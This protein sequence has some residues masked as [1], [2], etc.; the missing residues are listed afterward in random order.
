M[1]AADCAS[2]K[3]SSALT[4]SPRFDLGNRV[5]VVT[6]GSGV[7]GQ[8]VAAGLAD[9]GATVAITCRTPASGE[10][11]REALAACGAEVRVFPLDV[12]DTGSSQRCAGAIIEEFGR[13]DVLVNSMGG[14]LA[15]A[16]TSET[17]T[18]LDLPEEAFTSVMHLNFVGG[19]VTPCQAFGAA[20]ARGQ[21]KG[22][23]INITSMSALRPLT[24]VAGYSAAK[25]AVTNFTQWLAV[26]LARDCGSHV[27]VNAIAPGFF[28]TAQNRYLLRDPESNELTERGRS[29]LDHTPM[30]AFGD[31]DDLVGA[32]I[33]LASDASR[34]VT[35]AVIP[36]DGGFG[37]YAGV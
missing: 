16:T 13:V 8:A 27:R 22:S 32:A 4:A 29:V 3:V 24:R 36:I 6:G 1:Q 9:A 14:N 10:A 18:F 26:H 30:G 17:R 34:F 35:G 7:L 19:V 33:W 2:T 11:A 37:A 21:G 23:I 5:A 12:F 28:E 25:A 20:M 15:E 31:P